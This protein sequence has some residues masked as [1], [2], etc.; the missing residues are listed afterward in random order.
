MS[1]P[2][3]C[4]I[5]MGAT[6]AIRFGSNPKTTVAATGTYTLKKVTSGRSMSLPRSWGLNGGDGRRNQWY[7][8]STYNEILVKGMEPLTKYVRT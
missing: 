5:C 7:Y 3:K 6:N 8:N 2:I 4:E 1:T